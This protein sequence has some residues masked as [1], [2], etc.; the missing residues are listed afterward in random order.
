MSNHNYLT[1]L[2]NSENI[3]SEY[4]KSISKYARPLIREELPIILSLKHLSVLTDVPYNTLYNIVFRKIESYRI[5]AIKKRSGGKRWITVPMPYLMRVQKWINKNILSNS[6]VLSYIS[7]NSMAYKKKS[8]HIKNALVHHG[9]T[10]LIKLDITNFFESISERQVFHVFK[11]IGYKN[12]VAFI[13]TRLCTRILSLNNDIRLLNKE[14]R[15][16]SLYQYKHLDN[17]KTIKRLGH[18]PQGAPTSPMLANLVCLE[19][20]KQIEDMCLLE[21]FNYTRYADDIVI[22]GDFSDKENAINHIYEISKILRT[23]GFKTNYLKT[24]YCGAG[25]RKIITGL[26]IN[27]PSSLRV[28]S[29]YKKKIRQE[30]YYIKK[31]G[32]IE[33]CRKLNI[34]NPLNYLNRLEGKIYYLICVENE[35]G[36]KALENLEDAIPNIHE[37]RQLA[38][39]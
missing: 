26:C 33:H 9:E 39:I 6:H 22:S 34:K 31:Y 14:K 19:L 38:E 29:H 16:F 5:F 32:L 3:N 2:R 35:N 30:I 27:D 18:L 13:L 23:H 37:L 1:S 17:E 24:K 11:K 20:D 25:D 12:S 36:K 7:N 8:S 15:W 28:P 10:K 21:D 4:K